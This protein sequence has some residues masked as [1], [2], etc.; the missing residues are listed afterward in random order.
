[1]FVDVKIGAP[2]V[3]A[4]VRRDRSIDRGLILIPGGRR[5]ELYPLLKTMI[6]R[7]CA[8]SELSEM[9]SLGWRDVRNCRNSGIYVNGY[10][11]DRVKVPAYMFA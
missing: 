2:T 8:R 10:V 4:P 11:N 1:M 6:T 9:E 3:Y 5:A 7:N